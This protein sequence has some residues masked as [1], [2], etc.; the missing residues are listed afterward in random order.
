VVKAKRAAGGG[1]LIDAT[2]CL[3]RD[4]DRD[5]NSTHCITPTLGFG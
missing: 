1:D 5:I 2:L 3:V 4:G